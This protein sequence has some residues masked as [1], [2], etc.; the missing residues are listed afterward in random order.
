MPRCIRQPARRRRCRPP[1]SEGYS[2]RWRNPGTGGKSLPFRHRF[3]P[4]AR[5]N[6]AP[7]TTRTQQ[8]GGRRLRRDHPG[9]TSLLHRGF[10]ATRRHTTSLGHLV[11]RAEA[12][13]THRSARLRT[14]TPAITPRVS[15][16]D[17]GDPVPGRAGPVRTPARRVTM[18]VDDVGLAAIV[19]E[20]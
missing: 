15:T 2:R 6:A 18:V 14:R 7:E 19:A 11:G 1:P 4:G 10:R 17:T 5:T 13:F 9:L 3:A 8:R 16:K 20:V 12:R